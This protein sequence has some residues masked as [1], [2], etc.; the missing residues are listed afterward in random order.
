MMAVAMAVHAPA[1]R[2]DASRAVPAPARRAGGLRARDVRRPAWLG[3]WMRDNFGGD[4]K[5]DG[6]SSRVGDG[7]GKNGKRG[8]NGKKARPGLDPD[9]FAGAERVAAVPSA[10]RA[11]A[12]GRSRDGNDK[13]DA[14]A[15]EAV[16]RQRSEASAAREEPC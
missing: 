16:N 15:R 7:E 4:E 8:K 11:G 5:K 12:A 2:L 1:A 6:E 14:R 13:G 3:D 10:E 9:L